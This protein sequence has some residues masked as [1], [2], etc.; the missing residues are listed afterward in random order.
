MPTL[1]YNDEEIE[2]MYGA[3][4]EVL[5]QEGRGKV[6]TIIM[7]D[8]NSVVREG[9]ESKIGRKYGLGRRN[10]ARF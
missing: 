10:E 4:S 9:C 2:K 7:G 3:I 5:H 6:N 8:F 1:D